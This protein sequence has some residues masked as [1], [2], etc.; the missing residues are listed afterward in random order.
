[1]TLVSHWC[2]GTES[3]STRTFGEVQLVP[4]EILVLELIAIIDD[5]GM[6]TGS[7]ATRPCLFVLSRVGVDPNLVVGVAHHRFDFDAHLFPIDGRDDIHRRITNRG[8]STHQIPDLA[9]IP[10]RVPLD[11]GSGWLVGA[12][13]SLRSHASGSV[14][15]APSGVPVPSYAPGMPE[16]A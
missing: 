5:H 10:F 4:R 1:M 6:H 16:V 3:E 15:L 2:H 8:L 9:L 12:Q 13:G 7:V 11:T 14:P